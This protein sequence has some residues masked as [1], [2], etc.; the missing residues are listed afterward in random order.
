M[1]TDR[2]GYTDYETIA[3]IK[4][5]NKAIGHFFFEPASMRFFKSKIASRTVYG[6]HFFITSEQFVGSDNI[7]QPRR[8]TIRACYGGRVDTI[9][10][11]QQYRTIEEARAA[12]KDLV[13]FN[14]RV[15]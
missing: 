11:F 9:G 15:P 8:Y 1:H 12:V 6:G 3:E 10:D 7:A 5:A 4:E 14:K 2:T 13:K